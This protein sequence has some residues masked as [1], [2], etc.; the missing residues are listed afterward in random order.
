VE[1]FWCV[2]FLAIPLKAPKP[3]LNPP[4]AYCN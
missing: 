1:G 2:K 3:I 4:A